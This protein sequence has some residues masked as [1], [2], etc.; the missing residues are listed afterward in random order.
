MIAREA[1]LWYN[2]R[3]AAI[4]LSFQPFCARPLGGTAKDGTLYH[5]ASLYGIINVTV[6]PVPVA[7]AE[8][9]NIF[10]LEIP[11]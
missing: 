3:K 5:F 6:S 11:I 4:I 7:G 2:S 8:R 1:A 10:E 9:P